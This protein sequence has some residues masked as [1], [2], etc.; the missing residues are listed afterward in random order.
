MGQRVIKYPKKRKQKE[1]EEGGIR[2]RPE[3]E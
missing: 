3:T 1:E 2:Y